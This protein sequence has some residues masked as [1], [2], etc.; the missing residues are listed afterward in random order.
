MV[1]I[2]G[3]LLS[4]PF[5]SNFGWILFDLTEHYITGYIVIMVGLL[6]CVS[7]GWLFEYDSTAALSKQHAKALKYLTCFYWVPMLLIGFYSNFFFPDNAFYGLLLTIPVTMFACGMG[8]RMWRK[9]VK[10]G[11]EHIYEWDSFYAEII[12]CGVNKLSMSITSLS[13]VT[14]ETGKNGKLREKIHRKCWMGIFETWFGISLKFINPA[15]LW[16][17]FCNNLY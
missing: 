10:A 7:V 1:V 11:D 14:M 5:C 16:F 9:D 6:Q 15:C 12:Y 8:W 13:S 17:I 4:L 3:I 2:G